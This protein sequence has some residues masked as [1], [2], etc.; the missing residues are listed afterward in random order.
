MQHGGSSSLVTLCTGNHTSFVLLHACRSHLEV[1]MQR[2]AHGMAGVKGSSGSR[3]QLAADPAQHELMPALE[4]LQAESA[5]LAKVQLEVPI[6]IKSAMTRA[7]AWATAA[8]ASRADLVRDSSSA[9]E[10]RAAAA[11]SSSS[12]ASGSASGG[13]CND[14]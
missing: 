4:Q 14:M 5:K 12:A 11:S 10:G 13:C 9:V 7:A 8:A 6:A 3:S 1:L 2:V